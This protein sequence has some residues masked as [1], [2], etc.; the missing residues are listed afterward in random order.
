MLN[1]TKNS[2]ASLWKNGAF[3][4]MTGTFLSKFVVFF[5]SIFV[6]R[7]LSKKD[8]GLLSYAEN[9]YS[10][11]Y[12]F[13]GFGLSNALIRYIVLGKGKQEKYNIFSFIIKRGTI[14]NFMIVV[15]LTIISIF[16]LRFTMLE[17][18]FFMVVIL[19]SVLPFQNL[20]EFD[21]FTDRALF[22]NKR[23][24]YLSASVSIALILGRVIGARLY[25]ANGVVCSRLIINCV[26][27]ILLL[28]LI[29]KTYFDGFRPIRLENTKQSEIHKY[30]FQYMVTNGLWTMFMLNDVFLLGV[31]DVGAIAIAD[32]KVAYVLPGCLSLLSNAIGTF[33]GPYFVKN[34]KD[35]KWIKNSFIKTFVGS[36]GL[37]GL[38]S[39]I[40]FVFAP[41]FILHIYGESY[42]NVVPIMRLLCIS[43]FVNSALRYT[44][45]N[46]LAAMGQIKYN[47]IVSLI[48]FV[49]QIVLD[50]LIIPIYSAYGAALVNIIVYGFM[51]IVINIIF[52]KKYKVL[53]W[54]YIK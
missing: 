26:V 45:A 39:V 32:Y 30:S 54:R 9:F 27:S 2:I 52:C 53:L 8:F 36:I 29:K 20:V 16:G 50:V 1:K 3:H 15:F 18:S 49:L 43:A 44:T 6:V 40:L 33:V 34:E 31:F 46:I 5:G 4:I 38:A 42:I 11:A 7:L 19:L 17:N 41:F 13:A 48:G 12:I 24:A 14:I 37:I 47:M 28:L 10:Y 35:N 21:L 25:G 22:A 51:A 23:Y